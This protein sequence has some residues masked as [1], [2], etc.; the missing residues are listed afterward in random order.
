MEI[1]AI[2]ESV[3]F[4]ADRPL[5]LSQLQNCFPDQGKPDK[6]AIRTA[7]ADITEVYSTRPIELIEV[8]SGYR[9][10]VR[11]EYSAWVCRLFEERPPRYSRALMETLAIIAYRQPTT[12]GGIEEIRGV[13]VSSNIIR[14]LLDRGWIRV[15]GHREVPGRPA[16]YATTRSF[17][18]YFN[19]KSLS[20]LPRLEDF[21][22]DPGELDDKEAERSTEADD[23]T[24]D[25]SESEP[26]SA[27]EIPETG[28]ELAEAMVAESVDDAR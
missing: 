1:Q 17:L 3:L 18:D 10:Q 24:I 21:N 7:I 25:S 20:D 19:L 9:F 12:R 16:L 23:H 28:P 14:T 2:I 26:V 13:N 15:V 27:T 11:Q 6:A 8:S 5:N 4:A 22:D